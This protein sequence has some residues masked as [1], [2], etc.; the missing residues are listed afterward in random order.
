MKKGFSLP[1]DYDDNP[2]RFRANV[3]AVE[4]YGVVSDV[5]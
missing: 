4:T 2:E 5:H 1:T 3:R